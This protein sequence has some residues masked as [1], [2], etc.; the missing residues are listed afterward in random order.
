MVLN[1]FKH[2]IR[3]IFKS[4]EQMKSITRDSTWANMRPPLHLKCSAI[5]DIFDRHVTSIDMVKIIW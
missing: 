1:G 4:Q 5:S 3:F 2:L